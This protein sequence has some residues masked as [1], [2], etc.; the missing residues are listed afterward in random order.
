MR[1]P[2]GPGF[3]ARPAQGDDDIGV[4]EYDEGVGVGCQAQELSPSRSV[5]PIAQADQIQVGITRD[6]MGRRGRGGWQAESHSEGQ[7]PAT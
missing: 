5:D 1:T 2:A 7:G 6:A 3:L 4:P